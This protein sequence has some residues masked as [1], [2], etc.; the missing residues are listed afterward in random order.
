MCIL[1]CRLAHQLR[2]M[3]LHLKVAL[4]SVVP[5]QQQ[6]TDVANNPPGYIDHVALHLNAV[7]RAPDATP[8]MRA[9]AT[10]IVQALNNAGRWLVQSR[11]LAKQLVNMNNFQLAQPSTLTMLDTLL[12]DTT[13]AY[14]GQLNPNTNQ[15]VPGVLQV[16]YDIQRL[17]T[18]HYY[19]E[20]TSEYLRTHYIG[21]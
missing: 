17:A 3:Q 9:I 18:I 8:Q 21:I 12:T 13:Y 4:L 7:I 14:I 6:L 2:L 20:F 1:T 15:V 19:A 11:M 16:H 5:A 10:E